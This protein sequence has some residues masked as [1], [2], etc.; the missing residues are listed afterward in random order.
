MVQV[1]TG[2]NRIKKILIVLQ[3]DTFAVAQTIHLTQW[4]C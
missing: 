3:T 4:S 1:K 2:W